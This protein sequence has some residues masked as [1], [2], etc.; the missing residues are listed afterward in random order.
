MIII[1]NIQHE[2]GERVLQIN[3]RINKPWAA[4]AHKTT[5]NM[6]INVEFALIMRIKLLR[7][8]VTA[9]HT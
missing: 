3:R 8:Y 6:T 5:I 2:K 7:D 4:V 9:T 1:H